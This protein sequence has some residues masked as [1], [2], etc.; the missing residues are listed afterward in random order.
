MTTR[1]PVNFDVMCSVI[2]PERTLPYLILL[3]F[4]CACSTTV[5]TPRQP[6]DVDQIEAELKATLPNGWSVTKNGNTLQLVR[7]RK[8]WIYNPVQQDLAL[9]LDEWVK[10]VGVELNYSI[11]LRFEPLMPKEQYEQL[12]RERAPYEKI[13]NEGGRNVEE[14]ARGVEEF[15]KREVPVYFTDR[16]TIYADKSDAYPR[17]VYPESEASDCKQVIGLLDK[18][19]QRYE[20]FSGKKS[21]FQ[22]RT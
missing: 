20:P 19:F 2:T 10:K 21:D 17:L 22:V 15:H 18:M 4:V 5:H 12:I 13:V 3:L 1:R 8:L 16:F 6:K 14:W 11:T 9:T 7:A